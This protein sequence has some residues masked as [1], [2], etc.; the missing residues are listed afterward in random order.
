MIYVFDIDG[1]ICTNTNGDYD[2][3][4]PFQE[5]ITKNNNLYNEGH[6]IIYQTA[7]GMGRTNNNVVKSYKIF[8]DFTRQQL[9]RW[10]VKF[11]DL[12]M[13]KPNGNIYID[14]KGAN[15]A[16]FYTD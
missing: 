11:H 1:T 5:R 6:T 8:Y 12:F 15:D 9:K 4:K 16:D 13:G 2:S 3:A 7:R 14:D 10:G